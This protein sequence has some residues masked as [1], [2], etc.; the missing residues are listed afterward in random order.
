MLLHHILLTVSNSRGFN[1]HII[2]NKWSILLYIHFSKWKM[3]R[4]QLHSFWD[5][6]LA[7]PIL[8]FVWEYKLIALVIDFLIL[9]LQPFI[10]LWIEFV[11]TFWY[12]HV[13]LFINHQT[14]KA[15]PKCTSSNVY[16]DAVKHALKQI[17]PATTFIFPGFCNYR[18]PFS[19]PIICHWDTSVQKLSFLARQDKSSSKETYAK[20]FWWK[21]TNFCNPDPENPEVSNT[22]KSLLFLI[23]R[24]AKVG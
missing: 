21:Y 1:H 3:G 20:L 22:L 4:D 24:Q 12:F 19:Y 13:D 23:H 16:R 17:Q 5:H 18:H 7:W 10:L 8:F 9:D 14:L 11:K 6:L 2:V 15:R